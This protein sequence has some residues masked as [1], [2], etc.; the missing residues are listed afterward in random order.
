MDIHY[1]KKEGRTLLK[2]VIQKSA[3]HL[4]DNLTFYAVIAA[5]FLAGGVLAA[6]CAFSLSELD[7]KELMLYLND[8]FSNVN[9]TGSDGFLVF[10]LSVLMQLKEF[11]LLFLLS[12]MVIGAPF[13]V[14]FTAFKGFCGCFTLLFLFKTYGMKAALFFLVGMLPHCLIL[15]PCYAFLFVAC[16]KFSLSLTKEKF[17]FKMKLLRFLLLLCLLFAVSV[18]ASLLQAYIE[19]I[20]IKL[21]S[22]YFLA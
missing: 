3:Y 18:M 11:G 20:F 22:G 6:V 14:A 15:I 9:Q 16:I 21:I 4:K 12:V 8:F 1:D 5:A 13:V 7:N 10:K 19:P 2:N 17:D